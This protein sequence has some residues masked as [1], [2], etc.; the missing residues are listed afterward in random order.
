MFNPRHSGPP[1]NPQPPNQG[2][3]SSP[4]QVIN[5]SWDRIKKEF[6]A[7]QA[8]HHNLRMEIDKLHNEKNDVHKQFI[9]YYEMSYGLHLDLCKQ[10]EIVKRLNA[11]ICSLYSFVPNEQHN[12][13]AN[14]VE[15]AKQV[16][17]EDLNNIVDQQMREGYAAAEMHPSMG[18][19]PGLGRP[20]PGM[21]GPPG[22]PGMGPH[23]PP[24]HIPP[25]MPIH[26]L[27]HGP[28]L[29]GLP[30]QALLQPG[31]NLSSPPN[32]AGLLAMSGG[33]GM[34][35]MLPN[36]SSGLL[37]PHMMPKDNAP[38]SNRNPI[39]PHPNQ[40][41]IDN[42]SM[43]NNNNNNNNNSNNNNS[44]NNNNVNM[45]N[46]SNNSTFNHNKPP[47]NSLD[48]ERRA[49][50]GSS[51]TSERD[52]NNSQ[53]NSSESRH[54][55][56]SKK[57]RRA[58]AVA[59]NNASSVSDDEKSE[60]LI[61]D[62]NDDRDSPNS[63]HNGS[64]S[65]RDNG[66]SSLDWSQKN[67]KKERPLS[68]A[69]SVTSGPSSHKTKSSPNPLSGPLTESS[70]PPQIPGGYSKS[71]FPIGPLS[72]DGLPV[73]PQG[74]GNVRMPF[75]PM[76]EVYS[77]QLDAD[78]Q[79]NYIRCSPRTLADPQVP[80]KAREVFSL[81]HGEVVCAVA[82]SNPTKNIYTGGKGFVKV[83]SLDNSES[84]N[85]V[86]AP[87]VINNPVAELA[88]LPAD[89]YVR[90]CKLLPDGKKLIVGG[91]VPPISVWDLGPGSPVKIGEL[92]ELAT[93]CYALAI[94]PDSKTCITCFSDGTIGLYDV[95]NLQLIGKFQG[96]EDGASCI[97]ISSDG[98]TLWT[99]GLD[100][101]LK[102]WNLNS[103]K[104]VGEKDFVTETKFNSQIF[105][106]CCSPSG[107]YT[108][109]GMENSIIEVLNTSGTR[110]DKM[111]LKMH[112]SCV[113]A[114][115]FAASGKWFI[116]TGKDKLLNIC[117]SP[118]INCPQLMR[119]QENSS[120]LSCDISSDDKYFATG[121]GEKK[122]TVYEVL[123]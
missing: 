113:L 87:K 116:S 71:M 27:P 35:G 32:A 118:E 82:L 58:E 52:H 5:E 3:F 36:L 107:N 80:K 101:T 20:L 86:R 46:I 57:A 31:L 10:K 19:I 22:M 92:K 11:I 123:Y 25:N 121:S 84:N 70:G 50:S 47:R 88:C 13:V 104:I 95:H 53:M 17:P 99:G 24:I 122:A 7:L 65:P 4:L 69:S 29:P 38:P 34:P 66:G 110:S 98:N 16:S 114:L 45:S 54:H 39:P 2:Q 56:S 117:G 8:G 85:E 23:P 91:E 30:P 90:S 6:E 112:D 42:N 18:G 12:Q 93:A 100:T 21:A 102:S 43:N 49:A 9:M 79:P 40:M 26:G 74:P 72:Q 59:I 33:P 97:D 61:V 55:T 96:H 44:N 115:K 63:H 60:D 89:S 64:N 77:S 68:R 103:G 109:V 75:L 94:S 83:W 78:G 76:Q 51:A 120:V 48:G 37:P 28:P 73:P 81:E 119:F 14:S 15:R 106:L 1:N 105:S 108:S 67:L 62:G 41:P 111:R